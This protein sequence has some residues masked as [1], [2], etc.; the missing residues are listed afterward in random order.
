MRCWPSCGRPAVRVPRRVRRRAD[1]G[2]RPA[3]DRA[4][5]WCSPRTSAA[6]RPAGTRRRTSSST[7][8]SQ[9][10][11]Q[12]RAAASTS[13]TDGLLSRACTVAQRSATDGRPGAG[14]TARLGD[15]GQ[16]PPLRGRDRG[17]V[18]DPHARQPD[19]AAVDQHRV[20]RCARHRQPADR[21]PTRSAGA[22]TGPAPAMPSVAD[23]RRRA[24]DEERHQHRD[25]IEQGQ[26]ADAWPGSGARSRRRGRPGRSRRPGS[27]PPDNST[28]TAG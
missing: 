22:R 11:L 5:R 16:P 6:A 28:G 26:R 15:L 23:D 17:Q 9:R 24:G 12:G 20:D 25:D 10:Y 7:T 27:R 14:M 3:L 2:R 8:R 19:R 21:G 18:A 4:E 1:A 13:S